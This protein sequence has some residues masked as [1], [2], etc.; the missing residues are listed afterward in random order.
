MVKS[1]VLFQ[2]EREEEEQLCKCVCD[3]VGVHVVC[4]RDCLFVC[5]CARMYVSELSLR[6]YIT[7]TQQIGRKYHCDWPYPNYTV[8][9]YIAVNHARTLKMN[10]KGV[11]LCGCEFNWIVWAWVRNC[12][13]LGSM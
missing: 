12:S 1:A 9:L 11:C 13:L 7:Y 8:I 4:L 2:G 5:V 6:C 3:C 10:F